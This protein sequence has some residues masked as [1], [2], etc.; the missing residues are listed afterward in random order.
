MNPLIDFSAEN[1]ISYLVE[2]KVL[3][4][5]KIKLRTVFF[6]FF[7]SALWNSFIAVYRQTEDFNPRCLYWYAWQNRWSDTSLVRYNVALMPKSWT[8][9]TGPFIYVTS[10][11]L[12]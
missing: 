8:F 7:F 5:Q 11:I 12:L 4:E 9:E 6:I 3:C 10:Q 1:K 2:T